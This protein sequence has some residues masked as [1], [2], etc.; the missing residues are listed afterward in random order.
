MRHEQEA[1]AL[2][3]TPAAQLRADLLCDIVQALA[4]RGNF[5]GGL[6]PIHDDDYSNK[7]ASAHF[8]IKLKHEGHHVHKGKRSAEDSSLRDLGVLRV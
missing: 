2:A 7:S 3:Y 4:G 5:E 8:G 1:H 6:V